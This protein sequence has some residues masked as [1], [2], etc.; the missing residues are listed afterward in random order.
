MTRAII[1]VAGGTGGH[2]IPALVL[3]RH[4]HQ[5]G[6]RIVFYTDPRGFRYISPSHEPFVIKIMALQSRQNF[7]KFMFSIGQ[8]CYQAL[9]SVLK[10]RPW[11]VISFGGY[12][13]LAWGLVAG[14]YSVP[15]ILH[16]Q[17]ALRGR[18][19]RLLSFWA[20]HVA[21][22]FKSNKPKQNYFFKRFRPETVTG[23]P[24]RAEFKV[25]PYFVPETDQSF[26]LL[27][28]GGSQGAKFLNEVV[29]Q[30][31]LLLPK[32]LR[33][34]LQIEQQCSQDQIEIV[35]KIYDQAQV[36]VSLAPFFESMAEHIAKAHLIIARAGASTLGEI[37]TVGRPVALIPYPYA[38]DDHQTLN[39]KIYT[40]NDRGWFFNQKT[41]TPQ[42]LANFLI[43]VLENPQLLM[44]TT[45]AGLRQGHEQA[46]EI[47]SR[48]VLKN[49]LYDK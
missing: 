40:Q 9:K 37:A 15:L 17:N 8:C 48:L 49:F 13:A 36:H 23:L 41:L 28:V 2:V 18:T 26:H 43:R 10:D 19:N 12:S 31:I 29:P 21:L 16:E 27:V 33:T 4:L 20:Q 7:L 35:Q 11:G 44:L 47:L 45:E 32:N 6:Q 14:F 1:V 5:Q 30:A 42:R 25:Q 38:Q 24:V 22:T 46:A 39:A 34:R 3:A